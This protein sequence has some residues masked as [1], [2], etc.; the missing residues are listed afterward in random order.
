MENKNV[1]LRFLV[2]SLYLL[3]QFKDFNSVYY[4][5]TISDCRSRSNPYVLEK[6]IAISLDFRE[7]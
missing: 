7:K 3:Y 6:K 2:T 4:K 5:N 1:F